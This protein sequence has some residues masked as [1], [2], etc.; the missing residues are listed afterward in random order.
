M[1]IITGIFIGLGIA[2]L[3][4]IVAILWRHAFEYFKDDFKDDL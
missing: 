3:L 1:N 4:P 2:A